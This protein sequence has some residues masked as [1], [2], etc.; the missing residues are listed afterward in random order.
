MKKYDTEKETTSYF[1]LDTNKQEK[2]KQLAKTEFLACLQGFLSPL[3]K[4][5]LYAELQML[6]FYVDAETALKQDGGKTDV[7]LACQEA[8]L[9]FFNRPDDVARKFEPLFLRLDFEKRDKFEEVMAE[10]LSEQKQ[11]LIQTEDIFLKIPFSEENETTERQTQEDLKENYFTIQFHFG[12]HYR[13]PDIFLDTSQKTIIQEGESLR[14]FF[15]AALL[16]SRFP[17]YKLQGP[18]NHK[19]YRLEEFRLSSRRNYFTR[20]LLGRKP[21]RALDY[22]RQ[23]SI[24]QVFLPEVTSGL[25]LQQNQFHSYDIYHHLLLACDGVQEADLTLRLSAL[26]HDAGKVLTRKEKENGEATFYNHEMVS[27]RM[28]P[29]IMKR[30]GI[31][32]DIGMDVRFL[33]KN[34]MFH[35]TDDWTDKA[36]RRFVKR[37]PKEFM[38][39]LIQL[40][41]ADRKGSGKR[42]YFPPALNRLLRHIKTVEEKEK[43]FKVGD[44]AIGGKDLLQM[45]LPAGPLFGE[46]LKIILEEVKAGSLSNETETL[47]LK[48]KE[49]A[50]Q[51][52]YSI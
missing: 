43:E 46:I 12:G 48:A 41:I 51:K 45:G 6:A 19:E 42:N 47:L 9:Y 37:V 32:K 10:Y 21:S 28:I 34:H 13:D 1:S 49:L 33:V 39:R 20:M 16:A 11:E 27:A 15:F 14:D 24:L 22:L 8:D 17:L 18:Q 29:T 4:L 7:P 44:L 38:W 5:M 40:R 30:L 50:K 23:N 31:G 3:Q 36:I 2:A 25:G 26:L 52:G 35:Y